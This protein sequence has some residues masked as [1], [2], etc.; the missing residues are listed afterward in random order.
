ML[1]KTVSTRK[2]FYGNYMLRQKI[3]KKFAYSK[4]KLYLC[5]VFGINENFIVL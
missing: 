4:K 1:R 3:T 5:T 2:K